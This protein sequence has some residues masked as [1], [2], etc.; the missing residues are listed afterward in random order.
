MAVLMNPRRVLLMYATM[1]KNTEK[2]A[3]WFRE[4]FLQYG[5]EVTYL[6][7]AANTD[8]AGLQEQLYFDDYDLICLGSPIVGGAPLQAVIKAFSFGAGGTLEKEVQTNLDRRRLTR[9]LQ[10]KNRTAPTGAVAGPLRPACPIT[11]TP[12]PS[13]SYFPPMAAASTVPMK[14][15]RPWRL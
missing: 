14:P 2:V 3:A 13:E 9:L 15:R 11:R 10:P 5:W 12:G 7:I 1:T 4:T 6:R 8:W